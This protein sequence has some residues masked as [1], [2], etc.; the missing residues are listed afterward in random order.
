MIR[1]LTVN[2]QWAIMQMSTRLTT[3]LKLQPTSEITLW[4]SLSFEKKSIWSFSLPSVSVSWA[5]CRSLLSHSA[6]AK[7]L[8][9]KHH[10]CEGHRLWQTFCRLWS[11]PRP[12]C[13]V[14]INVLLHSHF[15][16]A[17]KD[18][19]PIFRSVPSKWALL[20]IPLIFRFV[21]VLILFQNESSGQ[22][23]PLA[24][25]IA[26]GG[27][28][29]DTI[30]LM[31][32]YVEPNYSPLG[33][34]SIFLCLSW[35]S[36]HSEVIQFHL[37]K[38]NYAFYLVYKAVVNHTCQVL[39]FFYFSFYLLIFI[40]FWKVLLGSRFNQFLEVPACTTGWCICSGCL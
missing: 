33:F 27:R 16:V 38:M 32:V 30:F 10:W 39:T 24:A 9:C 5:C 15:Y 23:A 35:S 17:A 31:C 11:K 2:F 8:P 29:L 40:F 12:D 4:I 26:V 3:G 22:L 34:E 36:L 14:Q 6:P 28:I 20:R 13:Q 18:F 37:L 21:N 19:G 25:F 7:W 1:T